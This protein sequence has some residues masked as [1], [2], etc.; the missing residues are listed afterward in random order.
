MPL[1]LL[2]M[3]IIFDELQRFFIII[4]VLVVVSVLFVVFRFHTEKVVQTVV[5][6]IFCQC[7]WPFCCL[8]YGHTSCSIVI[9][10]ARCQYLGCSWCCWKEII[11]DEFF[12]VAIAITKLPSGG[13]FDFFHKT[14]SIKST[15][16]RYFLVIYESLSRFANFSFVIW[17]IFKASFRSIPFSSQLP[18]RFVW[19]SVML[20]GISCFFL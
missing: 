9:A 14:K 15:L 20:R 4:L 12:P 3:V 1:T 19:D 5:V 10:T 7:L 13:N 8:H 6:F 16:C 11:A 2:V 18:C 17:T